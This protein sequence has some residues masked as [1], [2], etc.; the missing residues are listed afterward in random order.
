MIKLG[1]TYCLFQILF[2]NF[3]SYSHAVNITVGTCNL[4]NVMFN[5]RTRI[6]HISDIIRENDIDVMAFQE[7]RVTTKDNSEMYLSQLDHFNVFLPEYKWYVTKP[8]GSV[9]RNKDVYRT[10][11]NQEGLG[12]L[13]RKQIISSVAINIT[14]INNLD[15]NPRI[16]LHVKIRVGPSFKD[17]VNVIVVHFSYH[18]SQQCWNAIDIL[19]IVKDHQLENVIILGDFNA[20]A[21]YESPV[22]L[23]TSRRN[24]VC[25][26]SS[27][28]NSHRRLF[29]DAWLLSGKQPFEGLTF[30][31]M[32]SPG[33]QSR[34]DR[35]LVSR[36]ITVV[37]TKQAGNGIDYKKYYNTSVIISRAKSLL[38]TSFD[39]FIGRS[40]YS[41]FQD[42]GPHGS[43]R[44]GICVSG[45]NQQNCNTPDCYE[46]NIFKFILFLTII[47]PFGINLIILFFSIL[48][49]LV[50]SA[51]IRSDD[52]LDILGYKC[53]L[54]N[55]N[56]F[57][58]PV[59]S[60][61]YKTKINKFFFLCKLP[62]ILLLILM[63]ISALSMLLLFKYLF[64]DSI[65]LVYALLPEEMF[66]SDHL[67]VLAKLRW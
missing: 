17:T 47:I 64:E 63:L 5:W 22:N 10:E 48:K 40:G 66:P 46:C 67:I 52:I 34:P 13:S 12:V 24:S 8:A 2:C 9:T 55:L 56:L 43:C 51:K 36:N 39:A 65:Q 54:F 31:N 25:L 1:L 58:F 30:S 7:V 53:C 41:C 32:P 18:R 37:H 42:C 57:S 19:R 35:I 49:I 29:K 20:Y 14:N 50:V 60:R 27:E 61:R 15:T 26:V 6:E 38:A 21:D 62:P 45:G 4:W 11:W 16:A 33:L 59:M 44:C 23:F 3:E 28:I